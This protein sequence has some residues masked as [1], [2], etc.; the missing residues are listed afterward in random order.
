MTAGGQ[1]LIIAPKAAS[2]S[3]ETDCNTEKYIPNKRNIF[4]F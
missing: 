2:P 4:S 1:K 3:E